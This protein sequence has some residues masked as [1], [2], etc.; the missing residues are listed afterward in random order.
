MLSTIH[1]VKGVEFPAVILMNSSMRVAD[2]DQELR[3]M[4]VGMTRAEDVLFVIRGERE[5][6]LLK[7][8]AFEPT[9]G[10]RSGIPVDPAFGDLQVSYFG[11]HPW[12][13]R[14]IYKEIKQ[15]DPLVLRRKNSDIMI[16]A[17]GHYIGKLARPGRKPNGKMN[18]AWHLNRDFP[19]IAA[20]DGLEV[21]GVYRHYVEQERQYDEEHGTNYFERLCETV[22]EQ[23]FYYVI[24]IGGLVAPRR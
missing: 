22:K 1:K 21:T 9:S 4:Y 17:G 2:I 18:L 12:R 20:F 13:C 10:R 7:R 16:Y 8:E 14:K 6:R 15:S 3:T 5:E 11:A 23:G 19:G 24:E